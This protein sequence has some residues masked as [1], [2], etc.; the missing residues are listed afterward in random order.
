[1]HVLA[2][3]NRKSGFTRYAG[4]RDARLVERRDIAG[5]FFDGTDESVIRPN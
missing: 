5:E 2:R 4:N 1:V 3:D